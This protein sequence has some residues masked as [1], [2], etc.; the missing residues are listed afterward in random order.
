MLDEL[1]NNLIDT[2]FKYLGK[3]VYINEEYLK[4][5]PRPDPEKRQSIKESIKQDG[6][7]EAI[8]LNK[9]NV[10]LDGHTRIEICNELHIKPRFT[11]KSFPNEK[12]ERKYVIVVN[13]KRRHLNTLQ[14]V[15]L[16]MSLYE[17]I[18]SDVLKKQKE[19]ISKTKSGQQKPMGSKS[20]TTSVGIFANEI[21][22]SRSNVQKAIFVLKNGSESL[23]ND[24]RSGVKSLHEGYQEINTGIIR[25]E[26][27][28]SEKKEINVVKV[29]KNNYR[30]TLGI[31]YSILSA[32]QLNSNSMIVS[33]ISRSCN[34]SHYAVL[35]KCAVLE[36]IGVIKMVKQERNRVYVITEKGLGMKIDFDIFVEK[37]QSLGID[38]EL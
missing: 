20:E 16:T 33:A 10:V 12:E 11:V 34:L 7:H 18:Q 9:N 30:S 23:K 15:E 13:L 31:M 5:V 27:K 37:L 14:N 2:G 32:L 22:D 36:K 17:Q 29:K 8:V 38:S 6:L 21:G 3:S 35:E 4:L 25:Q 24:V 28:K 26:E 19:N 1:K